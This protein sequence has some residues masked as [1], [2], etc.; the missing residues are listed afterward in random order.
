[1]GG[2]A[3]KAK[4]FGGLL[5]A[6][7]CALGLQP[8]AA[9][10]VTFL[11]TGSG[12]DG[13]LSA[14]ADFTTSAGS[15]SVTLTNLLSA[16]TII[17]A[18]QTVSDLS[19][20]LSNLP[21][22]L[23][24]TSATGQLS[25]VGAGGTVTNVSGSPTRWLGAGGQGNFSIVGSTITLEA[26][27]GGQP[28]QLILPAGTAYPAANSSLT[29]LMFSPFVNG[30]ATF[31]LAL[32]GVSATTTITDATFSFGTQPD[33]FITGVP[34]AFPLPASLPLFASGLLGLWA[35]RRTRK[36]VSAKSRDPV[37]C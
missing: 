17:S 37:P 30:S 18:G 12:S 21:G 6:M 4:L 23:G 33:T 10:T 32:T 16:S 22:I 1:M 29:D 36:A 3:M 8:A 24:A 31:T 27:G 15:L 25:N 2:V 5:V 7:G 14:S 35:L 9:A 20:T 11:G 13:A 26:I 34:T 19:F 28:D